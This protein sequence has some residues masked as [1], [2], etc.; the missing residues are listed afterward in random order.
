[1]KRSFSFFIVTSALLCFC[2]CTREEVV[3][4]IL[5]I[6]AFEMVINPEEEGSADARIT[7]GWLFVD[8]VFLGV[9]TLPAQ[10][11]VLAEGST[12][13][14]LAAGIRENGIRAT[15]DI[16]PFFSEHQEQLNLVPGQT[17]RVQPQIGYR[18]DAAFG[19]IEDFEANRSRT[20]TRIIQ[21]DSTITRV[22]TDPFEGSFSGRI[23]VGPDQP[24]VELAS[25]P[26]FNGLN[27]N[28]LAVFLELHYRS[29][30]PV[31]FGWVGLVNGVPTGFYDPGF[32]PSAD[33]N[34]IYFNLG[35][36]L[37]SSQLSNYNLALRA[38]LPAG[39]ASSAEIYVDNIKL[40]YIGS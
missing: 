22:A 13:I 36:L 40:L 2:A 24:E 8:G 25:L 5:D 26:T 35:P 32:N 34:K 7:E 19:F 33:W 37:T 39:A 29:E 27:N 10:V 11:P 17:V 30:A 28:N 3:P 6:Q 1:M 14:R 16:Y 4:A 38:F 12:E 18:P 31:V 23:R 20:F 9:Y 21:G 15:P